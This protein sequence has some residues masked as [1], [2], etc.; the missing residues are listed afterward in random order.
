MDRRDDG[1]DVL[2]PEVKA[3]AFCE[4]EL[5]SKASMLGVGET[6][7]SCDLHLPPQPLQSPPALP[8]ARSGPNLIASRCPGCSCSG[9]LGAFLVFRG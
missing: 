2:C 1:F 8:S 7:E 4:Y 9:V 5:V 3:S 6:E